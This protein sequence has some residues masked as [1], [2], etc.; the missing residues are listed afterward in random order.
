MDT[1]M[2]LHEL[3][4]Q[5]VGWIFKVSN[6]HVLDLENLGGSH[7]FRGFYPPGIDLQAAATVTSLD[8]TEMSAK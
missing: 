7:S 2:F 8:A 4:L 5:Y 1:I 6:S 3:I